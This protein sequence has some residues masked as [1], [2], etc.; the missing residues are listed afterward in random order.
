MKKSTF[1]SLL[2]STI[3]GLMLSGCLFPYWEDG[4]GRHHGG[5]YGGGGY[6]DG[7]H[8]DGGNREGDHRH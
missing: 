4:G 6:S 8:H 2:L 3:A 5:G 1:I 7:G